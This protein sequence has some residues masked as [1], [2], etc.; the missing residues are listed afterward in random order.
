MKVSFDLTTLVNEP[1]NYDETI[2]VVYE[3]TK[4]TRKMLFADW[5]Q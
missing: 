4:S 5:A 2:A 3:H 1:D